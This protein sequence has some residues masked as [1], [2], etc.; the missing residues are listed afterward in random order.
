MFSSVFT[1]TFV[2]WWRFERNDPES[3]GR[4][5]TH[6]CAGTHSYDVSSRT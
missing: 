3:S 5:S 2:I 4:E 6:A 1:A